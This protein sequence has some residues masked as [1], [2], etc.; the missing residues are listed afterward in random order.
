MSA[1]GA[2]RLPSTP[3][4]FLAWLQGTP[5]EELFRDEARL[6]AM[7]ADLLRSSRDP[8][9]REVGQGLVDGS[10]TTREVGGGSAYADFVDRGL[11]AARGLDLRAALA[12]L[13]DLREDAA[14]TDHADDGAHDRLDSDGGSAGGRRD[15]Q[16]DGRA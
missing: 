8:L 6:D 4:E 1:P 9:A 13:D 3:E 12:E 2:E 10:L 5:Y 7:M 11:A 15:P 14:R 16:G